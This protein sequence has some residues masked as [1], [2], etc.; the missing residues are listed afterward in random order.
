ME[1]KSEFTARSGKRQPLVRI[2]ELQIGEAILRD[3]LVESIAYAARLRPTG[4]VLGLNA[5][6]DCQL[7][8]DFPSK[9]M[10]LLRQRLLG[11]PDGKRCFR[12]EQS[13]RPVVHVEFRDGRGVSR[14]WGEIACHCI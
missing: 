4:G 1:F 13:L 2:R 3:Y 9:E 11:P 5:F 12:L 7:Q 10:R 14:K 6:Q 8:L